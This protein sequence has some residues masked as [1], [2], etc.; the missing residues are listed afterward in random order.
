MKN[1]AY[2]IETKRLVIRCYEPSDAP[3][4][5]ESVQESLEHLL[6][7]MPWAADE[8]GQTVA[9]KVQLIRRFRSLFD[10]DEDYIYGIFD[11]KETK[12][13]GGSGLHLRHEKGAAEIGYW[14]NA[15]A[16]NKGIATE[17]THALTKVGFEVF[18]FRRIEIRHTVT[19]IRSQRVPEKLG[20]VKIATLPKRLANAK[21]TYSTAHVWNLFRAEYE[22]KGLNVGIALKAHDAM[23]NLISVKH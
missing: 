7:W 10:R 18:D 22:Q 16:I 3:L 2:R 1:I 15:N 23:G 9:D 8:E 14:I 17:S 20:Y 5:L 4:L 6:P 11:K 21:G 12:L 19:N 13:L